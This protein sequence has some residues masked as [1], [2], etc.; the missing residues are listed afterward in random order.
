MKK[1]IAKP[2]NDVVSLKQEIASLKQQL[3]DVK[4]EGEKDT[5]KNEYHSLYHNVPMGIMHYDV[6]GVILDCND[7]FVNMIGSSRKALV[8]LDMLN[9]LPDKKLVAAVK[10]SLLTGEGKYEGLYKSITANKETPVKVLFKGF[11]NKKNEIHGGICIAEDLTES[12]DIQKA[13]KVTEENT[14][15]IFENTTDVYY[16]TDKKG[17]LL[18]MNPSV[19]D[20]L[21]LDS[22]E[23]AIGKNVIEFYYNPSD[24]VVLM[25]ALK[26]SG[27]V[28]GYLINLKRRDGKKVTVELNSKLIYNDKGEIDSIVGVFHDV[29]ARLEAET[30]KS[31]HL[32]FL[33]KLEKIDDV[34][35]M[36]FDE[37]QIYEGVLSTVIDAFGCDGA[38]IFGSDNNEESNWHLKAAVKSNSLTCDFEPGE[39]ITG[40][41][42]SNEVFNRISM[43]EDFVIIDSNNTDEINDLSKSMGVKAQ[44]MTAITLNSGNSFI[45]CINHCRD[46]RAWNKHE[47]A[48]FTEITSRLTDAINTFESTELLY[49]SEE[50]HRRLIEATSEGYWEIDNAGITTVANK[51]MCDM[52]G[53]NVDEFIG[54]PSL[55]FT[56]PASRELLKEQVFYPDDKS[57]SSFEIELQHKNGSKIYTIFNITR[58]KDESNDNI[59]AF[60]FVTD[61]SNQKKVEQQLKDSENQ[62]RSLFNAMNDVVLEI[63]YE[64]RCISIAPT[65]PDLVF[66]P[67]HETI[68]KTFH[69]LFPD[70]QATQLLTFVRK[71]LDDNGPISIEYPMEISNNVLW[72]EGRAVPKTGNSVLFIAHDITNRRK[73]IHALRQSEKN[74]KEL[75]YLLR[76]I[77]DTSPEMIWAKD[78]DGN[79]TI[80][81]EAIAKKLLNAKDVEEPIGKHVMEFAKRERNLHPENKKWFTFGEES[82]D[83]D[84]IVINSKSPGR[85]DEYGN[86]FGKYLF[87]DVFKAPIFDENGDLSGIVG[88]A[89]D[90]TNE[91]TV[92]QEK[93]EFRKE[94]EKKNLELE[95][96]NQS[97]KIA[98]NKAKESDELKTSFI[99]NI[100]HEVR[101]PLN[102]IIGF[103]EM[104]N[105]DNLTKEERTEYTNYVKICSNQLTTIIS[106]ILQYSMLE[107]GQVS[108]TSKYFNLNNLLDELCTNFNSFIISR[109]KTN[110]RLI[111]DKGLSD[112][113][114]QVKADN[115]KIK[116]ILSR[117]L[118]NAIKFTSKGDIRFGYKILDDGNISFFVNDMGV[119]IPESDKEVIF[120]KFRH[121]TF[122]DTA[123]YGG[124]GLG[125]SISKSLVLLLGGSIWFESEVGVGT[126]FY[127]TIPISKSNEVIK[128]KNNV[129]DIKN[130]YNWEGKKVLII[131]DVL[132]VFKLISVY[133][134]DTKAKQLYAKNGIQAIELCK[135]N[136]DI[137]IV[138]LDIQLPDIDGYEIT[139]AI[140]KIRKDLPIIA[141]TAFVLSDDEEKALAAGFDDYI[142]KPI[143]K[144]SLLELMDKFL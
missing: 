77:I 14:S 133:L 76:K 83:T 63:D 132:E 97:L 94:L 61:I 4:A 96:L 101:T 30:E 29:T 5:N 18:S 46:D 11:Q 80:T 104:L 134:R 81:N 34:I 114:S 50:H 32:W 84:S 28:Q 129:P 72:F 74:H 144:K 141:Q 57:I 136:P 44:L 86:V 116:H 91:K 22:L 16:R 38:L 35:R 139:K 26:K 79:F 42:K 15:L 88:F 90:V 107:A 33:E 142:A 48:L 13:L 68:G 70:Q 87:L 60:F 105:Q 21:L 130:S 95:E 92:K 73:A 45:F 115:E 122:T 85:F 36:A 49:K 109:N 103:L 37:N 138:L 89:R 108:I 117:L 118:N 10:Q 102:G 55:S 58:R 93:E 71:C 12:V 119:G 3:S 98:F 52:L 31:I 124:N 64:G 99:K 51:A 17:I 47:K 41:D 20:M 43:Y 9:L 2:S 66:M 128:E 69:D 106:D 59:G 75:S 25:N 135:Q 111:P 54:K 113:E 23:Y 56:F 8:G 78:K 1:N 100:S 110:I 19:I 27:S 40:S 112:Q 131:D 53:Y 121:G 120:E 6:K 62:L 126:Q 143:F 137:D 125:L 140:K 123:V 127:V 7:S 24:S 65:N 67:P 82:G 39:L